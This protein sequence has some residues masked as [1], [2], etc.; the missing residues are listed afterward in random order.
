MPQQ[1]PHESYKAVRILEKM[2]NDKLCLFLDL[3]Y[4]STMFAPFAPDASKTF[5]EVSRTELSHIETIG[6]LISRAGGNP[7]FCIKYRSTPIYLCQDIPNR[8]KGTVRRAA[9]DAARNV[10]CI[11][12]LYERLISESNDYFLRGNI[13]TVSADDFSFLEKMKQIIN[14][15]SEK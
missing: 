1:L 4:Y 8:I 15:Y 12:P 7:I 13:K 3:T 11:L 6:G 10:T 5:Y 14:D 2:Y 9:D